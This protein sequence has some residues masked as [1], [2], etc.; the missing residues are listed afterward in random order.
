M[1]IIF[2]QQFL[3]KFSINKVI[4]SYCCVFKILTEI[5][6][7][8]SSIMFAS[9][10]NPRSFRKCFTTSRAFMSILSVTILGFST[11]NIPLNALSIFDFAL[12]FTVSLY[13]ESFPSALSSYYSYDLFFAPKL[14]RLSH[15]SSPL[16]FFFFL[17][18]SSSF[19]SSDSS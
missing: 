5:D 1:S 8:I 2:V 18:T 16:F 10:S 14:I 6:S 7:C 9:S 19:F 13:L 15:Y 11:F 4:I 3:E 17:T 12:Y